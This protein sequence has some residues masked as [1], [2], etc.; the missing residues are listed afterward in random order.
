MRLPAYSIVPEC[1]FPVQQFMQVLSKLRYSGGRTD[2]AQKAIDELMV[3]R[4][5][6]NE[7]LLALR[8]LDD[9]LIYCLQNTS[10]NEFDVTNTLFGYVDVRLRALRVLQK[11][12]P[13]G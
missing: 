12:S 1:S 4:N 11:H 7:Q 9:E 8:A 13:E 5:T 3:G 10:G 6:L 2:V